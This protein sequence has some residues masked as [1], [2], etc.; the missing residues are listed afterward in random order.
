MYY[1]NLRSILSSDERS[2]H[3]ELG[4]EGGEGDYRSWDS[5]SLPYPVQIPLNYLFL[6]HK[7]KMY[8]INTRDRVINKKKRRKE[9][10]CGIVKKK[11]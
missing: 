5:S 1:N 4:R 8:P 11:D 10:L 3:D 6:N 9:K 2:G 7:I